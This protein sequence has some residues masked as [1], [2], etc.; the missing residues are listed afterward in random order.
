MRNSL[1]AD[2]FVHI[3]QWPGYIK[4]QD[5]IYGGTQVKVQRKTK[6]PEPKV[7][8]TRAELAAE[9]GPHQADSRLRDELAVLAGDTTDDLRPV[10]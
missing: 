6:L 5:K 3:S 9:L 2:H 10:R 1:L 7:F 4:P 8:F